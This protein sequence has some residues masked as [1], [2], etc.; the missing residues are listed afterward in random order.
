L[1]VWF[2]ENRR[3]LLSDEMPG[4]QRDRI[5]D[6]LMAHLI[7]RVR[8]RE[9]STA[10]LGLCLPAGWTPIP[11]SRRG[12]GSNA[13]LRLLKVKVWRLILFGRMFSEEAASLSVW[14][15]FSRNE[16]VT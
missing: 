6:A 11:K 3:E 14:P 4:I 5:P 12:S 10:Q 15:S 2:V 8:G 13:F 16:V 7:R 9:I 1:A